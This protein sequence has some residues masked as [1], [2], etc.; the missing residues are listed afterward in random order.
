MKS[1]LV[2]DDDC[3]ICVFFKNALVSFGLDYEYIGS[4]SAHNLIATFSINQKLTQSTVVFIRQY[5][6][7]AKH[8]IEARAVFEI[9]SDLLRLSDDER[10]FLYNENIIKLFNPLYRVFAKNRRKISTFFGL[11]AC[12]TK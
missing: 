1:T 6:G 11:N 9:I 3:G 12:K 8:Y 7:F 5:A 4:S 10:E 2:F